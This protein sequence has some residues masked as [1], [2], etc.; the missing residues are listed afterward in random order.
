MPSYLFLMGI[1]GLFA[2]LGL[3]LHVTL[4]RRRKTI[5]HTISLI[6]IGAGLFFGAGVFGRQ[7]EQLEGFFF[8]MLLGLAGG[9]LIHYLVAKIIGPLIVGR[10]WCG[11]G[12][13]T[14]AVMSLLPFKRSKGQAKEAPYSSALRSVFFLFSFGL[15]AF[16]VWKIGYAPGTDWKTTQAH[17]WY[18]GGNVLYFSAGAILAFI[19]KDNRA[20]CKILC[21]ITVFLKI[22]GRYP[23]SRSAGRPW[24][25]IPAARASKDVR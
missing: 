10:L 18:I 5:A 23:S 15:V 21:P 16:L 24:P 3:V 12:C 19:Y 6:A 9:A 2:A 25:A 11:W 13:W 4:N 22:S 20:F 14:F 7:N 1:I 17:L 8:D